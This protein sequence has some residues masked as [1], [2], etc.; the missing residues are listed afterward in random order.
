VLLLSDRSKGWFP[1][2]PE[3][4]VYHQVRDLGITDRIISAVSA[5]EIARIFGCSECVFVGF[6]AV[7]TATAEYVDPEL[8]VDPNN[9]LTR[10]QRFGEI[11]K[12]SLRGMRAGFQHPDGTTAWIKT[13]PFTVVT[14]TGDRPEP[15]ALCRKWLLRQTVLPEQWIVVDDGR[16]PL[17]WSQYAG[18]D[19]V[20]RMPSPGHTIKLNMLQALERIRHDK[21][22]IMEDDDWYAPDYCE[23]MLPLLDQADLV[24]ERS[25][26]YFHHP[27]MQIVHAPSEHHAAFFKTAFTSS[28]YLQVRDI[29]RRKRHQCLIDVPLWEKFQ[30]SKI[31]LEERPLAVGIKGLPGRPGTTS[32]WNRRRRG[33]RLDVRFRKLRSLIG[34]DVNDYFKAEDDRYSWLYEKGP[35][36]KPNLSM[37]RLSKFADWAKIT[38]D[39][40][41]QNIVDLGCGPATLSHMLPYKHYTGVDVSSF[42]TKK[43]Q[44][45]EVRT[46]VTYV[47]ASIDK[48]PFKDMEFDLAICTDVMEHVPENQVDRV[49]KEMF[50]VASAVM[51]TIDCA[52]AR[53]SDRNGK[54][55]HCTVQPLKWWKDKVSKL[56]IIRY[57]D[58]QNK[59]VTFYCGS[60]YKSQGVFPNDL[61]GKRLRRHPDGSV[62]LARPDKR[63][64]KYMDQHYLRVGRDRRW[65][66]PIKEPESVVSLK[67]KFKGKPAYIVGKGPTLDNITEADF[68][69]DCPIL[70]LN[71]AVHKIET[72]EVANIY[73][74]QQDTGINCRPT[75]SRMLLHFYIK[76]LYPEMT[77][78]YI[79]TDTD[80]GRARHSL[81]VLVAIA[82]A[83][84]MG[85]S[86]IRL[87]AFDAAV[88]GNTNYAKCIGHDPGRTSSGGQERFLTHRQRIEEECQPL[89]FTF[90]SK[91]TG[92]LQH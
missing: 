85:C 21:C 20:R 57:E 55:L 22:I 10:F 31:L 77:E 4:Y 49:F 47:H 7:T 62:W 88:S 37:G 5:L 73:L 11:I 29:C 72:L 87:W 89:P 68:E 19:Y 52:K 86:E 79:F 60:G 66:Y 83:K 78:R 81:T 84:Y 17:R 69:D 63:V 36:S 32:G 90:L 1:D 40:A 58:Y 12:L 23:T 43:N 8:F 9:S 75:R 24:G 70:V 53:L 3:R 18:A 59:K 34:D 42:Q 50:R 80:F 48:L 82:A 30:G 2:Y 16:R 44:D 74:L 61:Y 56:S 15:F 35:Y 26:Y 33:Y 51:L 25:A 28:A 71:E 14:L 64:E 13:A 67:G 76:H 92:G 46:N 39:L 6:D 27:T 91:D 54:N 65:H 45:H 38:T 41:K